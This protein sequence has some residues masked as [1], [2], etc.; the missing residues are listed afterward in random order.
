M[1]DAILQEMRDDIKSIMREV[2]TATSKLSAQAERIA[3]LE[4]ADRQHE[5]DINECHAK[6]R[7]HEGA[8]REQD[9]NM[10]IFAA[11]GTAFGIVLV[12]AQFID[13][14]KE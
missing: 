6:H 5:R 11:V 10:K 14:F 9:K 12:V 8:Q 1:S 2:T 13:M 4:T 3:K 7:E